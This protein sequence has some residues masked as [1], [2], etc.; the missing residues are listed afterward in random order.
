MG[1]LSKS[2][3][4]LAWPYMAISDSIEL[5]QLRREFPKAHRRLVSTPDGAMPEPNS[6]Y[7]DR[8]RDFHWDRAAKV[9]RALAA[10][11]ENSGRH[12]PV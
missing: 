11:S 4:F 12:S 3:Q 8:L 7:L 10:R 1:I 5:R 9:D 6:S 2:M